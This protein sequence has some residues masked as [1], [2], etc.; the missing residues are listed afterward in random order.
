[1]PKV[2]LLTNFVDDIGFEIAN[3]LS[4][5]Q[6]SISVSGADLNLL[7]YYEKKLRATVN[8]RSIL[9]YKLDA[10]NNFENW[11]F[12][13]VQVFGQADILV[14]KSTI[15]KL[16]LDKNSVDW[17]YHLNLIDVA[18]PFLIKSNKGGIFIVIMIETNDSFSYQIDPIQ[19]ANMINFRSNVEKKLR[20][21]NISFNIL[22]AYQHTV[23]YMMSVGNDKKSALKLLGDFRKEISSLIS[24]LASSN[25]LLFY[26]NVI[27]IKM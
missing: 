5:D 9:S 7:H 15:D 17:K 11:F 12:Q 25:I 16:D 2:V 4:K 10:I 24:N 14:S 13:T 27:K 19:D 23:K 26:D 3:N 22:L 8:N 18:L 20:G 6:Y 1:M 21:T